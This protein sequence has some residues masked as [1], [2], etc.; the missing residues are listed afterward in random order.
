MTSVFLLSGILNYTREK[1]EQE[2]KWVKG[3]RN[4]ER[5]LE[6]CNY[7][8]VKMAGWMGLEERPY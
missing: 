1:V 6:K 7:Q 4:A 5:I 2:I 8:R 3:E